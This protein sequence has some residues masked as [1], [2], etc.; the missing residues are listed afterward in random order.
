MAHMQATIKDMAVNL[1][2][3]KKAKSLEGGIKAVSLEMAEC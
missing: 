2:G 3:G 1:E